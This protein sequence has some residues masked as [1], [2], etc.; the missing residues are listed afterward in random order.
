MTDTETTIDLAG[1]WQLTSPGSDHQAEIQIPGDVHSALQA[2]GIIVDPY[3]G[4][5]EEIVQWV[6]HRDWVL[7]RRFVLG[8]VDG[9]WYLDIDS[10][11]TVATVTINDTVVLEAD[12]CFR[13]YRPDVSK[14][15]RPGENT[16]SIVLHSSIAVGAALQEKQPFYIPY[17]PGNSPIANGNMLRK[18]QSHFGWDWN[19]AIAPLGLYG[20]VALRRLETARIESVTTRQ[21]HNDD[22]T[23]DLLV[24]AA[25][26]AGRQGVAQLYFELDG[27][28][29]RLDCGVVAGETAITHVFHIDEP[30]LWWPAGSGEQALYRLSVETGN[31]VVTR[32]IGLRTIELI[33]DK[34]AAGSRF[35]FKV[36]GREIFCRGANW[37]PADA[38]FSRSSREK[39]E[40]LLQSAA[41]VHMNMIRVWGGGFYEAGWF[42]DI[43]DRLG[44]M[45][46][47]DFMFACNL[48]P[49][50][51]DFLDNVAAEVTYQ[52]KRLA[53]HPS[54]ALWC[55]DNELVGALTW[56]EESRK[57]R[58][59]YLV[60]YD[61]LNRTIELAM[62]QAAPE[63]I[64]WPSSPASGYLDFGDAWHADGS[65]D[66]HYWS[67]WHEN[68]S[69]DNYRSVRP[70]FCSEFGFQSYTSLP[71]I[72]TYAEPKDMNVASPVM[73][74]HQKNAGGNQRIAATMFRYFR[75]PKD[76]ANFV[77]L[78]QIQQALAIQTAVDYWRSLKPHCM[79]TIY[80]QLNDT[81]PVASWSSL[82][83][84]GRWKAM[85]YMVR[86]F[87]QPVAV[88]AIPSEDKATIRMSVVNDTLDEV[89]IDLALHIITMSGEVRPM[90]SVQATCGPDAA[91][92]AFEVDAAAIAPG[93]LLGW[94]FTASNGMGGQGHYVHGTYKALELEPSGLSVRRIERAED[95]AVEMTLTASGLALFVMIESETDGRYSDN[96]FDLTAGETRLVRF[97]PS[98]P[99][100]PDALPDFRFYDLQSCQS[101]D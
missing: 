43:C 55:G 42:Y 63:A 51:G 28:R 99:M 5:N 15:L 58:D 1:A 2:A 94:T 3:V 25:L 85:H 10:L 91:V 66:M 62:K 26:F 13:R 54:I 72:R 64:W 68:K 90:T 14:A 44:L 70:R 95:G 41:D 100:A 16:L 96:A 53:S 74:L 61:R 69:F 34:D 98:L 12:N 71:V 40:D 4:R 35:A 89:S 88:A 23:V 11:D 84:G 52:V 21:M 60:S 86:R 17:H 31:E 33:T 46:W 65:G 49:S 78:S 45:I 19:I 77:Y 38:L 22:G 20:T 101:L 30:R 67:V 24:T 37:I 79:G 92:T 27:E 75:F 32:Q 81:W 50:T 87:F 47:Q 82:D 97:M 39:T 93:C 29:V 83:Y 6:A 80:W 7:Q 73:E 48:Y 9:D 59:R 57:D 76:F 18:P 8:K 56:F 36:N